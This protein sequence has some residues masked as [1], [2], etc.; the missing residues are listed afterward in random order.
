M[1]GIEK[2]IFYFEQ[3][4][5]ENSDDVVEIVHK[6]LKDGD[7]KSVVVASSRGETGLK[8]AKKMA[9]ETNLVVVT[10]HPGFS[11]PGVWNFN[12]EILKKLESLGCRVVKQSHIL[13]GL[14]RSISNRFSGVSHTEV[15]A[16][17]LRCLLGVGMKVAIECTIMAAD[18]GGI[19]I[20]KTIAVGG[21]FSKAGGGADC[22]I[23]AWPS[24]SNNFFD[25]R[26]LEI[27]AKPYRRNIPE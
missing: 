3:A 12:L 8:F 22:A 25:F 16:E 9:H 1:R 24:H 17:S 7:I 4:G 19:S 5:Y 15:L 2:P 10:S 18:S 23:V 20:E 11:T 14:E 13:S 21:T 6:R 27:L 26:V